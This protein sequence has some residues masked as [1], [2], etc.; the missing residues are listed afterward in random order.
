[1][2]EIRDDGDTATEVIGATMPIVMSVTDQTGEALPDFVR[3]AQSFGWQGRCIQ[4]RGELEQ[5]FDRRRVDRVSRGEALV[6][7]DDI[8]EDAGFFGRELQRFGLEVAPAAHPDRESIER[9]GR[10]EAAR[11]GRRWSPG[12]LRPG[13]SSVTE[14]SRSAF[15]TRR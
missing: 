4:D 6:V 9:A 10:R 1:M 2:A 5:G 11:G 3:L 13:C 14:P 15:P 8:A 12:L 7:R